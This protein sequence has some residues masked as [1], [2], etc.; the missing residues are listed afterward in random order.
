MK[1]SVWQIKVINSL[2]KN[3]WSKNYHSRKATAARAVSSHSI[4]REMPSDRD[5]LPSSQLLLRQS[6]TYF[7]LERIPFLREPPPCIYT[8][9]N[10]SLLCWNSLARRP[11]VLSSP[12]PTAGKT[13]RHSASQSGGSTR[14]FAAGIGTS[15]VLKVGQVIHIRKFIFF[16]ITFVF[17]QKCCLSSWNQG[18]HPLYVVNQDFCQLSPIAVI[19]WRL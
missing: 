10:S 7:S 3:S 2:N 5:L 1:H 16:S 8:N 18:F 14:S 12:L 11:A 6:C 13:T 4:N 17:L 9:T 19:P 15:A